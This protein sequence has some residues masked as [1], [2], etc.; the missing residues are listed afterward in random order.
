M[1]RPAFLRASLVL[2]LLILAGT[3]ASAAPDRQAFLLVIPGISFEEALR[4]PLYSRLSRA[5]GIGLLTTSGEAASQDDAA[6]SLGAGRTLEPGSVRP[7]SFSTDNTEVTVNFRRASTE[8][9]PGLLGSV[10]AEE[11]RTVA[12]LDH[13][14]EGSGPAMLAAMDAAGHIPLA[15]IHPFPT[16]DHLP[17]GFAV[18]LV[19]LLD[20][21]DLVVSSDPESFEHAIGETSAREVLVIVVSTP[22]SASMRRGGDLVTPIVLARGAP[23]DL[24]RAESEPH[25]LTSATTRRHGIVSNVDVAPTVLDFLGVPVPAEMVGAPITRSGSAPTDL[26]RRYLEWRRVVSPVGVGA[27]GLAIASL[28]IGFV[29]AVGLWRSRPWVLGMLAALG[30]GSIA[31]VVVFVPAS[32][33][34]T[35]TWPV[36]IATLA[37]GAAA[38]TMLA[39]RLGRGHP[40]GPVA[41]VSL[42]GLVLVV[43]DVATGWHSGLT[44]LLGGS[45][46]DGERF[47]GLGNPYAGIVLSGAV[48]SAAFLRR[49]AGLALLGGTA[50]F[51]GLPF[52][53]AD[54]GGC[55]TLAVAAALWYALDRWGRLDRRAWAL[56]GAAALLA[57]AM[58]VLSHGLLPPG[59]THVSRAVGQGGVLGALEIFWHRLELN[60]R[61]TSEVPSA[62]LAVLGLPV[63]LIVAL[64]PPRR[65]KPSVDADERWRRAIVVLALSGMV[66][67]VVN[68][69]F[70]TASIAFLFLSVAAV[71]PLV[72]MWARELSEPAQRTAPSAG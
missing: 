6:A 55:I 11:G 14:T 42:A 45:A 32:L 46:M 20:E 37:V 62:W 12:Y 21:A 40:A 51:A 36:L 23:G 44:P 69:T 34:P 70:G 26:H 8:G 54:V 3:P 67:Y 50:A 57:V 35:F 33:L 25:G 72:A 56:A 63:W 68:D 60:I 38:L 9:E 71:Y 16:L 10:L 19:P 58:V 7:F 59:Q 22:P 17:P 61:L 49:G 48:L 53:G 15:S 2:A 1:N 66:G 47:F 52:L 64:R 13:S 43:A 5:G 4:D 27:L 18:D 65:L 30:L 29:L 39:L 31:L 41:I 24:L 28:V